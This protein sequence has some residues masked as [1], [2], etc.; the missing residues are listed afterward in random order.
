M[1]VFPELHEIRSFCY[2]F[3]LDG[4]IKSCALNL[5]WCTKLVHGFSQKRTKQ[6][7]H[8]TFSKTENVDF[9]LGTSA[10]EK[11]LDFRVQ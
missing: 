1:R 9:A 11:S 6:Q 7:I 10:R 4:V 8:V 2:E 5:C 3:I